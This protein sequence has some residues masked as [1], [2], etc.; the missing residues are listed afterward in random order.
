MK[1]IPN[2]SNARKDH[3]ASEVSRRFQWKLTDNDK[4]RIYGRLVPT[5]HLAY[6]VFRLA[7]QFKKKLN[8][9][10]HLTRACVAASGAANTLVI[11]NMLAA[12][13]LS[14]RLMRLQSRESIV[15]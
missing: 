10:K 11:P 5:I 4:L 15:L 1:D 3:F 7:M 13:M 8:D 2:Q 9:T 14:Q 6:I 12:L